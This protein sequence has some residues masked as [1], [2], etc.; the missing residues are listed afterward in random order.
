[1]LEE[2]NELST[3]QLS[4]ESLS[5]SCGVKAWS[6]LLHMHFFSKRTKLYS[7]YLSPNYYLAYPGWLTGSI[8]FYMILRVSDTLYLTGQNQIVVVCVASPRSNKSRVPFLMTMFHRQ[9]Q[10]PST[11][12]ATS[13]LA[14][15]VVS[16]SCFILSKVGG[17]A[18]Y[19]RIPAMNNTEG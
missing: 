4:A 18:Y 7:L 11:Q 2:Y 1:M 16:P 5:N 19:H 15:L 12:A 3:F 6:F 13:N 17:Q 10:T 14:C 8:W 9:T